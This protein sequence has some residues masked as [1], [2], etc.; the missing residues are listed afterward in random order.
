MA[1]TDGTRS[2][3]TA[4]RWAVPVAALLALSACTAQTGSTGGSSTGE[5]SSAAASTSSGESTGATSA[6]AGT[7]V[8][9]GSTSLGTV[10]VDQSGLT[11]YTF[12]SDTQGSPSTCYDGCASAWPPLLTDGTPTAGDGVDAAKLGTAD[13]TDGTVQVTYD[14]WPLYYW[15]QDSQPGD[16]NGEGVNDV[17]WVLGADG[18]PIHG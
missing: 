18:T 8:D 17:W 14:G 4:R 13:R 2:W 9:L 16:V 5:S 6:A 15:A 11:L 7:A 1:V 3:R 10:L 12:D